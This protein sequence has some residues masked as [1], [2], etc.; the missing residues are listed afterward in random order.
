MTE[1]SRDRR[2][3]APATK[4]NRE[5]ILAVL[6]RVLPSSGMIL[7]IGSGTGEHAA[8]M[9]PRLPSHVWVP[10][11]PRTELRDSIA[12]WAADAVSGNLKPPRDIDAIV[13]DWGVD[14]IAAALVAVVNMNMIHIAPWSACTG[15]M[16]GAGR[17]LPAG[18]L[19]YLYGP[20]MRDGEH[21]AEGNVQ[22]DTALRAQDPSWG[23][24]NLT[25]VAASAAACGLILREAIDMPSDNLSVIFVRE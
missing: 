24:R 4:R 16:A 2:C 19:L 14:D 13:D 9:A 6:K 10:S 11:D 22:F 23:V 25:D 17:Y 20:F 1:A 8:W 7:E 5:P 15:L 12:A 3:H 21:T 18:G